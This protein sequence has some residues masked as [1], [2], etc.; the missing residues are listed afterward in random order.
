[1]WVMLVSMEDIHGDDE[2]VTEE[3]HLIHVR[4]GTRGVVNH[5]LPVPQS[6]KEILLHV[7]DRVTAHANLSGARDRYAGAT[8]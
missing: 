5:D 4:D 2:M 3:M 1:M 8:A 7:C 6:G